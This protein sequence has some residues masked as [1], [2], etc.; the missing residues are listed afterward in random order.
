MKQVNVFMKK[1]MRSFRY[2]FQGIFRFFQEEHNALLHLMATI[3]V[4]VLA[5]FFHVQGGEL[6]A[7]IIVTGIV[8]MAELFNTAIE[9]L[10]DLVSKEY[11]PGIG[12]LKDLAAAAVLIAS[13]TAVITGA[14]IFLPKL[15]K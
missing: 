7:L 10:A 4:V 14:V 12:Y 11:H 13:V 5:I 8:W 6:L 9:R 3:T 15:L 2:A 1:R